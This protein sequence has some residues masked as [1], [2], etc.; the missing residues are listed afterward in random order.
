MLKQ[1]QHIKIIAAVII[2]TAF[3]YYLPLINILFNTFGYLDSF[4]LPELDSYLVTLFRTTIFACVSSIFNVFIPLLI[5]ILLIPYFRI[6]PQRKLFLFLLIPF[7]LG[8]VTTSFLFKVFLN[9][10]GLINIILDSSPLFN[11]L[12]LILIQFWQYG[13]L[14]IYI[15]LLWLNNLSIEYLD[16]S[17]SHKLSK[18][19]YFFDQILPNVKSLSI[20]LLA[21][22]F[23]FSFFELLKSTII[24]KS[25]TGFNTE[26]INQWLHR[27]Y[28]EYIL[29]DNMW[30][31]T[32]V[33]SYSLGIV[34]T[35]YLTLFLLILLFLKISKYNK[36]FKTKISMGLLKKNIFW[37][38]KYILY[39]LIFLISLP[40]IPAFV[41][42]KIDFS[43]NMYG[44]VFTFLSSICAAIIA[45]FISFALGISLRI[46]WFFDKSKFTKN[47]VFFISL[48]F[49]FQIVSP[50]LTALIGYKWFAVLGENIHYIYMLVW[51]VAHTILLLPI[52]TSFLLVV[53]FTF[54]N[55]EIQYL[56][57]HNIDIFS[58]LKYNVAKRYYLE[59]ILTFLIAFSYI[60]N[61]ATINKLFSDF[62]PSYVSNIKMLITGRGA[63]YSTALSFML[64]SAFNSFLIVLTWSLVL[65]KKRGEFGNK[66]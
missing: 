32:K 41:T 7:T 49:L 13:F 66:N 29:I 47:L 22:N 4:T 27:L 52:L 9:E 55:S 63:N 10:T 5:A 36:L 21:L 45:T 40:F 1:I 62:I 37:W 25:S 3:I 26:L 17:I 18:V 6:F 28:F 19:E 12:S 8:Q 58:I 54:S 11:F 24:F 59:I 42:L 2:I 14:F 65:N 16:Y 44:F 56:F 38:N 57:S 51:Y 48:I 33:F 61:E 34:V 60:W 64:L 30:S 46:G 39:T 50:L 20:A 35:I 53:L 43:Q 31:T 23:I 15:Y